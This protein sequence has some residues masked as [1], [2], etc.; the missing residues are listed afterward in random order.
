VHL[1]T[2]GDPPD[3]YA[4]ESVSATLDEI[5]IFAQSHLLEEID[6]ASTQDVALPEITESRELDSRLHLADCVVSDGAPDEFAVGIGLTKT[7]AA[8]P[9][10]VENAGNDLNVTFIIPDEPEMDLTV[11]GNQRDVDRLTVDDFRAVIDVDG[12]DSGEHQVPV[13]VEGPDD[14]TYDGEY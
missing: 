12:L 7:I 2:T 14:V 4:L 8:V 5:A 10:E 6:T 9:I 3:G 13:T 11:T 1:P